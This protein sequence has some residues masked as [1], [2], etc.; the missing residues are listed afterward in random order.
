MARYAMP[1]NCD[2]SDVVALKAMAD[3]QFSS[4]T[5]RQRAQIIL[6]CAEGLRSKEVAKRLGV[7]Q[8]TVSNVRKRYLEHGIDGL[9]DM[10]R[11][12]CK[13]E[14]TPSP[15]DLVLSY[16]DSHGG[17]EASVK[18][19]CAS[20]G[21]SPAIVYRVL[22][23][24]SISLSHASPGRSTRDT[25]IGKYLQLAGIYVS[26]RTM[27]VVIRAPGNSR[28][29]TGES[30]AAEAGSLFN[31]GKDPSQAQ[32]RV[33]VAEALSKACR[34]NGRNGK[35]ISFRTFMKQLAEGGGGGDADEYHILLFQGGDPEATEP[36]EQGRRTVVHRSTTMEAWRS[37]VDRVLSIIKPDTG[38]ASNAR[39]LSALES[40]LAVG[41]GIP[42]AWGFEPMGEDGREPGV[43]SMQEEHYAQVVTTVGIHEGQSLLLMG[44]VLLNCRDGKITQTPITRC[45]QV[46]SPDDFDFSSMDAYVNIVSSFDDS[47]TDMS[48]SINKEL[49]GEC[50]NSHAKKNE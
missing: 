26:G 33:S 37:H 14:G 16:L 10:K 5:T 46:P 19:V 27:A 9:C 45:V 2:E 40:Y 50:L 36:Y 17:G 12:G 3:N 25:A 35:S 41:K 6:L 43:E 18:D 7:R 11:P 15:D 42:F 1:I 32:G 28:Q 38:F 21:L 47:I 30:T 24:H 49:I 8:N 39:L 31:A 13:G 44:G 34:E 20:T 4:K 29:A 23:S 22:R 48:A